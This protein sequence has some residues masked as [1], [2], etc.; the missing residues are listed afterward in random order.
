MQHD[1]HW[2]GEIWN[3]RRNGEVGPQWLSLSTVQDEQGHALHYAGVLT[4]M[5]AL[6]RSEEELQHLA[7]HD[8]LTDLPNRSQLQT[9]LGL[10]LERAHL[11]G[12]RVAVLNLDLDRFKNVNDSM[13][14]PVGDQVLVDVARRLREAVGPANALGR[15]GGDEFLVVAENPASDDAVAQ[16][17][18]DLLASLEN[19]LILED[20]RSVYLNGSIGISLFPDHGDTATVLIQHAD[21]A[22]YKAKASGRQTWSLYTQALTRAADERLQ[23]ENR[24]RHAL[25]ANS[26]ELRLHFQPQVNLVDSRPF[27]MEALLRWQPENGEMIPPDRF[28]PVAEDTKLIVALGEWVLCEA[29]DAGRRLLDRGAGDQPLPGPAPARRFR[30]SGRR[31]SFPDRLPG[32]STKTGDH[33]DRDHAA[34]RTRGG[35]TDGVKRA[36]GSAGH[37]SLWYRLFLTGGLHTYPLDVLKIDRSFVDG[38]TSDSADREIAATII[39]M[40]RNLNMQVIAEGVETAEQSAF[41]LERGC[42]LGQGY[43]FSRPLEYAALEAWMGEHMDL[44]SAKR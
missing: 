2:Q 23:L 43:Y 13:G 26:R 14:H 33:R 38:V 22:M 40:G 27:G 24:L 7:Q 6:R 34:G 37:R 10:A 21:T 42:A 25:E 4:D 29:C 36:G 8:A 5:S 39:A 1:G 31:D 35:A 9:M 17:A 28:I 11:H 32:G 18:D 44:S 12:Y 20:G 16:C 41:L 15:L 3:R 19:P 30:E